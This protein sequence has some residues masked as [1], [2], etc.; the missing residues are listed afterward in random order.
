[1]HIITVEY[2]FKQ[3]LTQILTPLTASRYCSANQNCGY[4]EITLSV[5]FL[6]RVG[7]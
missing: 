1:M 7:L 6:V 3:I 2:A 4:K 5:M